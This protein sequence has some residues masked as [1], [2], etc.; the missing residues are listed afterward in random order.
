M[1]RFVESDEARHGTVD[2][3]IQRLTM[4]C[5]GEEKSG[6]GVSHGALV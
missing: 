3:L 6:A 5:R 2:S 1:Q 4:E